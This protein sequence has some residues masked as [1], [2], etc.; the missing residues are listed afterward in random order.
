MGKWAFVT[1]ATSTIGRA[2]ALNL[3]QAGWGI[4]AGVRD[5]TAAD[6]LCEE[7]RAQGV[8]AETFAYDLSNPGSLAETLGSF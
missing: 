3:A 6:Q 1:G 5:L 8:S 2:V 4:L 7:I